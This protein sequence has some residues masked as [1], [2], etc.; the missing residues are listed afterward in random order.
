MAPSNRYAA[1]HQTPKGPGDS[2]PTAVQII[3]DE[4][5][6]GKLSGKVILVTGTSSGLGIETVT[7]LA[8]TGATVY[9]MARDEHKNRNALA[10][11]KG[12]IELIELDLSS[13]TKV[14]AAP[15]EFLKRSGTL[16]ILINNAG[17]MALHE[18]TLTEDGHEMQFATNHLG[19]FLLFQLLKPT[20]LASSTP[21]FP[22]RVV[23]LTSCGHRMSEVH[24]DNLTLDNGVYQ[25]FIGYAQS[26]TANIYM[27]NS[28]ERHYGSRGLH[29]LSVHP[30]NIWTGL[31]R[32][33]DPAVLDMMSKNIPGIEKLFKSPEQG[34]ATT[35]LAAIG[36]DYHNKG[37]IYLEE[38]GEGVLVK[39]GARVEESGYADFAFDPH[40]E[41]QMW[42]ESLKLA[43]ITP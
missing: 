7:A 4:D 26:K 19:H 16:N 22:S 32:H 23:N 21:Q 11:V 6:E 3:K 43:N 35:I 1:A 37:G 24:F 20:L 36:K 9:C 31:S 41:E 27:A 8:A 15:D 40:K 42:I 25:P 17:I 10:K 13:F 33:V 12:K 5:M 34:A 39:P 30:G 14:R 29:G 18:R 2:R 28:I 38:C